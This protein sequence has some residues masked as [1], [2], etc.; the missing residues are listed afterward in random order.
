MD[1]DIKS[2]QKNPI[3]LGHTFNNRAHPIVFKL[4]L[5]GFRHCPNLTC[6]LATGNDHIVRNGRFPDDIQ[7]DD[8]FCFFVLQ[9]LFNQEAQLF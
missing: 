1:D 8:V 7:S 2:I 9:Y 4:Y 6:R 5:K 3:A